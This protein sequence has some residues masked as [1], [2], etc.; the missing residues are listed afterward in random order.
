MRVQE[1]RA[2]G[3]QMEERATM[4]AKTAPS[5]GR[6][7]WILGAGVVGVV[8]TLS[9]G[10]WADGAGEPPSRASIDRRCTK[11]CA[12]E[13]R[14]SWTDGRCMAVSDADCERGGAC[15]F[16]G[17]CTAR[18]GRCLATTQG[19]QASTVC[20]A[21]GR[22]TAQD[23]VCQRTGARDCAQSSMCHEG[24]RCGFAGGQCVATADAC[25]ASRGCRD[26]GL[27]SPHPQ[28]P[29]QGCVAASVADCKASQV[30]MEQGLCRLNAAAGH[31][32]AAAEDCRASEGCRKYGRCSARGGVC[33]VATDA[34][35]AVTRDCK[36]YGLC[37]LREG[38]CTA[39]SQAHCNASKACVVLG[40]C[41]L[42]QGDCVVG[43]AAHC[44][45]SR[46]CTEHQR[47]VQHS[48]KPNA[49]QHGVCV[50][51]GVQTPNIDTIVRQSGL[52]PAPER[53]GSGLRLDV[54]TLR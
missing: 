42:F 10:A 14:C 19:C 48:P 25:R 6:G 35:C 43:E 24:G 5:M 44:K 33:V 49:P 3:V 9:L 37:A 30:C 45:A 52:I 11:A 46:G 31:C 4:T 38:A 28:R 15:R 27:C 1:R 20:D 53:I 17:L 36:D 21:E 50:V 23:G 18:E 41:R 13:G 16:S 34:D 54:P 29:E 51:Q 26:A 32:I 12:L 47:C 8:V 7:T 40:E 2:A 22:C 39:A